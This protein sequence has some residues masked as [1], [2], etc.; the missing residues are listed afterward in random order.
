MK[1]EAKSGFSKKQK[2]R[3]KRRL[4]FLVNSMAALNER[5]PNV[6]MVIR[7]NFYLGLGSNF[8]PG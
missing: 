6:V 3:K 5:K 8:H 4:G 2:E 1:V 7:T